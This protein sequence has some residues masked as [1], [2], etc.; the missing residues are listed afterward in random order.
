MSVSAT[1]CVC[2]CV[3]VDGVCCCRYLHNMGDKGSELMEPISVSTFKSTSQSH[4]Q[5]RHAVLS[6]YIER[7]LLKTEEVEEKIQKQFVS[8][9]LISIF[10]VMDLSD[11]V[12]R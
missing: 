11:E 2:V 9:Q 12:G 8:Q 10:T 1:V 6:R 7:E 4:T 3:G 5:T